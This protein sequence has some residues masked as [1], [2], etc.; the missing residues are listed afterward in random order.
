[1]QDS[2]RFFFCKVLFQID[3]TFF[4][5]TVS[6]LKACK[7]LRKTFFACAEDVCFCPAMVTLLFYHITYSLRRP[8]FASPGQFSL[9]HE[10]S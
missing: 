1:M 6:L 10:P 3:L 7:V 4:S 2:E 8:L 9:F 5:R